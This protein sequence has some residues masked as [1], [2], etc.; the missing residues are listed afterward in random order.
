MAGLVKILLGAA[1]LGGI[2]S[3]V[4]SF[5]IV[6]ALNTEKEL[7][8]SK[9]A[10][11]RIAKK[12]RDKSKEELETAQTSLQQSE[13][14]LSETSGRISN[15]ESELSTAK[16]KA[17][18]LQIASKDAEAQLTKAQKELDKM[19]ELIGDA[20][21]EDL[22]QQIA[23]AEE[24]VE[25][26]EKEKR[27][28]EDQFQNASSEIKRLE[29][30]VR[31]RDQKQMPPGLS[32]RIATVNPTWNFVVLDVGDRDGVVRDGVLLVYRGNDY[33]GKVKVVATEANT[34]VA[35]ILPEWTKTDILPGDSVL[36]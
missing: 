36:N 3:V 4:L 8:A 28:L 21:P 7:A 20:S 35:D 10:D 26:T 18:D 22:K 29:E 34:A 13:Q 5:L 30:I 31:T 33:I 2:A 12:E 27:I 14:K 24:Q 11:I 9:D 19:K 16:K 17:D 23:Q 6:S 32:G 15:L 1:A 25:A